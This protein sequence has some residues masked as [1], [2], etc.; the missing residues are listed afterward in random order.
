MKKITIERYQAIDGRVFD[1]IVDAAN[2][3][4]AL[5]KV[6]AFAVYNK[7]DLT[8]G[9]YGPKFAGYVLINANDYHEDFANWWAFENLGNQF[10]FAQG[11]FGSNAI[12]KS[13]LIKPTQEYNDG[14]VIGRVEEKFVEKLWSEQ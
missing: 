2:H 5:T 12:M 3:E 7:P 11:V 1:S 14:E 10:T 13:W 6:R 4:K 9:R 8:E